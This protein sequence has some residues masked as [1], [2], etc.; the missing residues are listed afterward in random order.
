MHD[1][2][3][4]SESSV[5]D[6]WAFLGASSLTGCRYTQQFLLLQS[7]FSC[8]LCHLQHLFVTPKAGSEL[9]SEIGGSP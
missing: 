9:C 4:A 5:T 1:R 3:Q 7:G 2:F 6:P 8:L